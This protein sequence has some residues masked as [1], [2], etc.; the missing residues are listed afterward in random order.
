MKKYNYN[1]LELIGEEVGSNEIFLFVKANGST[2]TLEKAL[3][4]VEEVEPVEEKQEKPKKSQRKG[5]GR[6]KKI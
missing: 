3:T 6:L 1:G 4:N 5:A 2:Y